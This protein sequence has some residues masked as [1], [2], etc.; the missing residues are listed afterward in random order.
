MGGLLAP[1]MSGVGARSVV[2]R[3]KGSLRHAEE[4]GLSQMGPERPNTRMDKVQIIGGRRTQTTTS[5]ATCGEIQITASA[6]IW[7]ER[8]GL[9]QRLPASQFFVPASSSGPI[10]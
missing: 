9:C 10:T 7:P 4:L 3:V 1:L 2:W 8:S 6:A 5:A